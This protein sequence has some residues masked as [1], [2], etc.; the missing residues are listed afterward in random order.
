MSF[1][2]NAP[3]SDFAV[4][5]ADNR[6]S[7]CCRFLG[8]APTTFDTGG[9]VRPLAELWHSPE[10]QA[11]RRL[12][13]GHES[14][15]G[16]SSCPNSIERPQTTR[17]V[18][19]DYNDTEHLSPG[20]QAN[21]DLA[22]R[23]FEAGTLEP[24]SLP[25]RY[26]LYFSWFCNLS[27][28]ICNQLPNRD[29]MR[30]ALPDDLFEQWREALAVAL[31]VECFGGEPF[32][33]PPAIAFMRKFAAD[34][35]M[36]P[37]RLRITTNG[38]L[39]HKHLDWLKQKR[40]VTLNVSIDSIG[41]GYE[42]IRVG[43]SWEQVRANL[44]AA[45]HIAHSEQPEWVVST[46]ALITKTG[47][48]F[49]PEFARFHVE[50][51]LNT[52]FQA[53]RFDRGNEEVLYH[54]D[55]LA[56]PGLLKEVEGWRDFFA[57]AIAI[58]ADGGLNGAAEGLSG[59]YEQ[60]KRSEHHPY[61]RI[62]PFGLR[63]A[64]VEGAANI[65]GLVAGSVGK[66][67]TDSIIASPPDIVEGNAGFVSMD[68]DFGLAIRITFGHGVPS[69]GI[70]GLRLAWSLPLPVGSIP[71]HAL[72]YDMP[73][74]QLLSWKEST[75]A[76]ERTIDMVIRDTVAARTQIAMVPTM[77]NA[78]IGIRNALPDRLEI[79]IAED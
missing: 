32:T 75:S 36:D 74:F 56:F 64:V 23:E 27:C 13:S 39:L 50:S 63:L 76:A 35:E 40:R 25:L 7:V 79:W 1:G 9:R 47:I 53:L 30:A 45:Q 29:Q 20:Q 73:P 67:E 65:L 31:Q 41:A 24:I 14:L 6:T 54:E 44:L 34:P 71:C 15:S 51:G 11:V 69:G 18:Y 17:Q 43:G 72:F 55:V 77:M 19:F 57:E 3:W 42:R 49:L 8:K 12:Q 68:P 2:C 37:V 78:K 66:A 61:Y 26:L 21:L 62:N 52:F 48:P 4:S 16:C 28:T 10:I 58:L 5:S 60:L 33:I 46:N 70:I 59:F 22:R 38:T